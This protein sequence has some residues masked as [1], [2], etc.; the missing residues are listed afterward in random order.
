M[1]Q[2]LTFVDPQTG[3]TRLIVGDDQGVFTGVAA[4][5]GT[6]DTAIG[7]SPASASAF[8]ANGSVAE[9]PVVSGGSGYTTAPTVTLIGGG[10]AVPATAIAQVTDGMVTAILLTGSVTSAHGIYQRLGLLEHKPACGHAQRRRRHGCNGDRRGQRV[11]PGYRDHHHERRVGLYLGADDHDRSPDLRHDGDGDGNLHPHQRRVGLPLRP[12]GHHRP[13]AQLCAGGELLPQ[14]QPP[15]RPAPFRS[16]RAQ[17]RGRLDYRR[18]VL[19]QRP[20][21]R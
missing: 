18:S 6:L 13:A 8:I 1:H 20:E 7:N 15:D 4:G 16:G 10:A 19:R 17:H 9:I 2:I 12:D 11:R 21:R 5:D 14:R 3:Q